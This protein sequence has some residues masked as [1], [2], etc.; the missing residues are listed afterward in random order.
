VTNPEIKVLVV[1]DSA[2]ISELYALVIDRTDGLECVG[3]LASAD[4][5]VAE[6][7]RLRPDVVL[8][9]LTMPGKDPL[10]A[11]AE[12]EAAPHQARVIAFSGYDDDATVE[13]VISAGAWGLVSKQE[14]P[15]SVIEA[16]RRV[17]RGEIIVR[18]AD[19]RSA[20]PG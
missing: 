4:D 2:A 20:R 5:L 18:A 13:S 1:D 17:M 15:T 3:T 11:L 16:V 12:L 8:L 10:A 6:V 19:S 14:P 9:D 7:A